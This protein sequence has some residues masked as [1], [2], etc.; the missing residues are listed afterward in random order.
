MVIVGRIRIAAAF[1][2]V[3]AILGSGC[4]SDPTR[5]P[6]LTAALCSRGNPTGLPDVV[7]TPRYGVSD[8]NLRSFIAA[9][10]PTRCR[11]LEGYQF[12]GMIDGGKVLMELDIYLG[13]RATNDDRRRVAA[14]L[15][16]SG[17]ARSVADLPR[18]A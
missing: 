12:G 10:K 15:R 14:W 17:L 6:G 9:Y 18:R 16:T 3:L 8:A 4:V 7:A 13:K 11:T 1:V 2:G 5:S